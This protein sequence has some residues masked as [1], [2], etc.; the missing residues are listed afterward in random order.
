[1]NAHTQLHNS[2]KWLP[3]LLS[4]IVR[5]GRGLVHAYSFLIAGR[6]RGVHGGAVVWHGRGTGRGHWV[7]S[8]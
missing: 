6:G 8:T 4:V 3:G 1:M 7:T 5:V 2:S